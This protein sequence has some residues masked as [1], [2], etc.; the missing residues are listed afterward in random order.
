MFL[1][2]STH[3]KKPPT[4]ETPML[5]EIRKK[6]ITKIEKSTRRKR[7][8]SEKMVDGSLEQMLTEEVV[9]NRESVKNAKVSKQNSN[10]TLRKLT[11]LK[12]EDLER[13]ENTLRNLR[14][15][16]DEKMVPKCAIPASSLG[17]AAGFV[18]HTSEVVNQYSIKN[19][20]G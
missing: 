8:F 3:C 10:Q 9:L 11:E 2:F 14:T 1:V 4:Q 15:L 18:H 13:V 12:P 7:C 6:M 16:Q 17:K 20:N 5:S 19:S